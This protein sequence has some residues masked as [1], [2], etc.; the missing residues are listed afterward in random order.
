MTRP[1]Q[2]ESM[3]PRRWLASG[4][5]ATALLY[6]VAVTAALGLVL[7]AR[8]GAR[9]SLEAV[10][11]RAAAAVGDSGVFAMSAPPRGVRPV[12]LRADAESAAVA[13]AYRWAPSYQDTSVPY[14]QERPTERRR[15]CGQSYY[16]RPVIALPD[17]HVVRSAVTTNFVMT[18]G[19]AWVV[20]ACDAAGFPR[21]TTLVADAPTRLRVVLG[22]HPD[23]VPELVFPT[24]EPAHIGIVD[25]WRFRDW[26]RGIA[27]SPEAAVMVA[28]TELAAA[29]ARVAEVPEAF[30]VVI[31]PDVAPGR[32]AVPLTGVQPQACPRW[33]ITLDRAVVLRGLTS[34]QIVR[35]HTVYVARGD[36]GCDGAPTLQIPRPEQPATLPFMYGVRP[37]WPRDTVLVP[38]NGRPV[39]LPDPETRWAALR[40]TEPVWFE[41]A[42]LQADVLGGDR[43]PVGAT[44]ERIGDNR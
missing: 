27:L 32:A 40:V 8:G 24:D 44:G 20:P 25:P 37:G 36:V 12:M 9:V 17:S 5:C 19:P 14:Y 34:N 6:A 23:D 18:W 30:V 13:M 4:A 38:V 42:R 1:A 39:R 26:E 41:E 43:D 3:S 28:A 2:H 21:T 29:G 10:A 31:P 35:T 11:G 15:L 33:R 22:D 16:V 7:Q